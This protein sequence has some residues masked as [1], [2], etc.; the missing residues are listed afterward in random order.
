MRSSRTASAAY[1][2]LT[3]RVV[4]VTFVY[5]SRKN[6]RD[7]FNPDAVNISGAYTT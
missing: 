2:H 7:D 3:P 1:V 5:P 4:R 6:N